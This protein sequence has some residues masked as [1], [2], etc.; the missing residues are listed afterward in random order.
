MIWRALLVLVLSATSGFAQN[1]QGYQD[2]SLDAV[3]EQWDAIT[4]NYAS[5]V[6]VM[7][8]QNIKFV[9]TYQVPPQSCSNGAL[10]GVL[11]TVGLAHIL[12]QVSITNC[13]GL[14]SERGRD[15]LAYVQ[16]MLVPGLKAD[17]RIG[18]QIEVHANLFAYVVNADRARNAPIMLVSAFEPK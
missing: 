9:A 12:K 6:S 13:V 18:G 14:R 2:T 8:P 3:F 17:A 1:F 4:K 5:G 11:R 15:V 16:D 7:R 10:E